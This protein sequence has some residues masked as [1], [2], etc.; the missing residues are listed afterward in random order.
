M[1]ENNRMGNTRDLFK[2]TGDIN[3]R[4]QGNI[5]CKK[6]GIIKDGNVRDLKEDEQGYTELCK[7][8]LNDPDNQ[9][10]VVTHPEADILECEVKWDLGSTVVNKA[11]RGDGIPAVI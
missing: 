4:Y 9:D 1:D 2:K 5:S 8:C 10:V 6:M 7:K 11:S 3:W